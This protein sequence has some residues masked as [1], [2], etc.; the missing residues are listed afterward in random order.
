MEN[1]NHDRN[2]VSFPRVM[3]DPDRTPA[4]FFR[5]VS[6]TGFG[7]LRIA[8]SATVLVF[9]LHNVQDIV[10]YYGTIGLVPPHL[11][12]YAFRGDFRYS[13]LDYIHTPESMIVLFW[14]TI[15]LLFLAMVGWKPRVTVTASVLLLFSFHER[16]LMILGGGDTVL[17][18]LGFILMVCPQLEALS[19]K[20]LT[21]QWQHWN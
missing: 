21:L 3:S 17:R 4:F 5:S 9:L 18:H 15:V 10:R 13:F 11:Y 19:V 16:N 1:Q 14:I 20:R 8:W 2:D 12:E 7:M 6:A